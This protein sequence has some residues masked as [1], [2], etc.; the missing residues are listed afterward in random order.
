[1]I[2]KHLSCPCKVSDA[3]IA[4]F[5]LMELQIFPNIQKKALD[6]ILLKCIVYFFHCLEIVI[7][8]IPQTRHS[9]RLYSWIG[10]SSVF[11]ILCTVQSSLLK[12]LKKR[13]SSKKLTNTHVRHCNKTS[14][15]K[16]NCDSNKRYILNKLG[17]KNVL[18]TKRKRFLFGFS[19]RSNCKT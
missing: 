15:I 7:M 12:L 8:N 16:S 1:M 10:I 14:V 17:Y 2:F 18:Q 3:F 5:K 6:R 11:S 9:H 13:K 4:E 19:N